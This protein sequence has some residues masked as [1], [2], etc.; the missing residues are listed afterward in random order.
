MMNMYKIWFIV[1]VLMLLLFVSFLFISPIVKVPR[2]QYHS[3][4]LRKKTVQ[5]DIKEKTDFVNSDGHI[6][7]AADVGPHPAAAIV[8]PAYALW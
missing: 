4:E 5:D 2:S 8:S 3:S 7:I 1:I 6:T